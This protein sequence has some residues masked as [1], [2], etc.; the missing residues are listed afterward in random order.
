M[1]ICVRPALAM[2]TALYTL[3]HLPTNASETA[4][5]IPMGFV[6][7]GMALYT[8]TIWAPLIVHLGIAIGTETVAAYSNPEVEWSWQDHG[9]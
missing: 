7:G 3:A 2:M 9:A 4:G 8:G 1:T 6:F 5:C